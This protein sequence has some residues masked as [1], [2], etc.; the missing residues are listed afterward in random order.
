MLKLRHTYEKD[1]CRG[2]PCQIP[3]VRKYD[4]NADSQYMKRGQTKQTNEICFYL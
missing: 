3:C 4:Y 2:H 1:R